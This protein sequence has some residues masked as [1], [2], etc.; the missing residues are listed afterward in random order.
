MKIISVP[1]KGAF[2]MCVAGSPRAYTLKAAN[3]AFSRGQ[4]EVAEDLH[5]EAMEMPGCAFESRENGSE[6]LAQSLVYYRE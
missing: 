2:Y 4:P 6:D 3:F 5:A 1:F